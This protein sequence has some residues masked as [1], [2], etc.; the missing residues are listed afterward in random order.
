V[1]IVVE[2][3]L[4][5]N[6]FG[7]IIPDVPVFRTGW[8]FLRDSL[9]APGGPVV[10]AHGFLSQLY[11]HSPLGALV[12]VSAT[13]CLCE[14][15]RRHFAHIGHDRATV[16]QYL[17]AAMVLLAYSQYSHPLAACLTSSAG[18][19][20]SLSLEKMRLRNRPVRMATFCLTAAAGYWLAGAG[21]VFV[22]SVMTAIY[23][24]LVHR[25]WL[26]AALALPAAAAIIGALGEYAFHISPKQAFLILTPFSREMNGNMQTAS[27]VSL[28]MIYALVPATV[29]LVVLCKSL[30]GKAG[31]GK[32]KRK[33][34][35][36]AFAAIPARFRKVT[37]AATAAVALAAGLYLTGDRVQKQIVVMNYLSRQK[38]WPEVLELARRLPKN[39]YNIY[40]NHDINRALYHT[41]RLAYDMLDFPQNPHAL[42]LT[43][44]QE[45]SSMTQLKM[46]D[47]FI[48]MGN[49]NYAEKLACE[50]LVDKGDAGIVLENL[51]RISII[52]GQERT[53]QIYLNALKKDPIYRRRAISMLTG[54]K[55]GFEPDEAARIRRIRSYRRS[56]GNAK[57]H[58]ES[59][60]QMLRELLRQNP[61]NRMAFEYLMSCYLLSGQLEKI[62]AN[63]DRLDNL[64]YK[65]VPTLY[66]EAMLIYYG[67]RGLKLNL[68]EL[69]IK[70]ETIERHR[71]FVQLCNSMQAQSRQV[72]MQKLIDEFGTSYFFYYLRLTT[73]RQA[74]PAL[75]E[76][77]QGLRD[78]L[79]KLLGS[80]HFGLSSQSQYT[81]ASVVN[82]LWL[83]Q[84]DVLIRRVAAVTGNIFVL[85]TL[86]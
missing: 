86:R 7:T 72:L 43:H 67:S 56:N 57:L 73:S 12:I 15:S 65:D 82:G 53:A 19:L 17:P 38:R 54:L 55:N 63:I 83:E 21:G 58:R 13:L 25:D 27:R 9:A 28:I 78:S 79:L 4:I 3:H 50:F 74:G 6:G 26:S 68:K 37:A 46:C 47:A 59:I 22:F 5:Y 2:P 70:R 30:I 69:N 20:L 77:R 24:L 39:I 61:H 75:S 84:H 10:Y 8:R 71:R 62:A 76:T 48:E 36:S 18:L 52:K 23:L 44:E 29:T 60:E 31:R 64:G 11:F 41:G 1:W 16:A 81:G 40:C 49:V 80:E 35:R 33:K 51:T 45:E 66:G 42:L 34:T 85:P 14:L 32:T